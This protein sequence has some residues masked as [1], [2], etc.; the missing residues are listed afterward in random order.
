[1]LKQKVNGVTIPAHFQN[2]SN[3]FYSAATTKDD[4]ERKF[5]R[6]DGDIRFEGLGKHHIRFGM[7]NE[8][9]SMEKTTKLPGT[10]PIRYYLLPDY[11]YG[12][13]IYEN[14]GG[15]VSSK[16]SAYYLQ[17]SWDVTSTLNLQVG[18]RDDDFKAKNLSGQQFLSLTGNIAPRLGIS[19][20]PSDDSKWRFTAY[21]G[22][23][24]IPPA[25]NLGFRGK[26]LYF[27]QYFYT[28]AGGYKLDA[29]GVPTDMGSPFVGIGNC[30][31]KGLTAEAGAP[32]NL[33]QAGETNCTVFGNGTQEPAAAKQAVG[34]KATRET[35]I[36]LGAYYRANDLWTFD[37]AYVYRSL[38]RVSEDTDFAPQINS[39]CASKGMTCSFSNEYHVWNVGDSVTLNTFST[40]PDGEKQVT[41]KNLG[42]PK[43]KRNYW[44]L[45]FDFKRAF[46][47]KWGIQ[48]SYTISKE[49]GNYEG[50]VFSTGSGTGQTDAGSTELYDYSHLS[51][52]S[53]G[54]LINS[55]NGTF[56]AFGSYAISP[57]LLIG[58]NVT[59]IT[60]GSL[61]C[62]GHYPVLADPAYGYGDA[63]HYC[64]DTSHVKTV[65]TSGGV[66]TNWYG[67]VPSPMG[68]GGHTDWVKNID[69]SLRYTVPGAVAMGGKLVLRADIFNL[70][71]DMEATARNE[72]GDSTVKCGQKVSGTV[73]GT[74][75]ACQ[76][77]ANTGFGIPTGYNGARTM[78]VGFDITY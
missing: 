19:W 65:T 18:I 53:N 3:Q 6:V 61:S 14:L 23:E 70:F 62:Y 27:I 10:Q 52:Y 24:Y 50:T 64:L 73:V 49:K 59:V 57:D 41:F 29:N 43:P 33:N 75:T 9:L 44:G 37:L 15:K 2:V 54:T 51:D 25:M 60:P 12:Y 76:G 45:T 21:Y 39:Y 46:D 66:Q 17:D 71:D 28:P 34:M 55:R 36:N 35:E 20:K 11:S 72:V 26:D 67:F 1:V 32:G 78:R 58:A 40:L 13:V 22:Q 31:A 69:L 56:K 8:D 7:D 63:S 47:G 68:K 5:E 74:P 77:T 30:P 38:D 42:F 16:D 48:G 4:W